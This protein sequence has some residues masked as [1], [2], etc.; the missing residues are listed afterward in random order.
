MNTKHIAVIVL[1]AA[2]AGI[3]AIVSDHLVSGAIFGTIATIC[4]T[5]AAFLEPPGAAK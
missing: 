3:S 5:V 2:A 4:T 1:T